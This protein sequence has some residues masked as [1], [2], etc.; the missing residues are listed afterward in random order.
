MPKNHRGGAAPPYELPSV[1]IRHPHVSR[2]DL[3]HFA[4]RLR[5]IAPEGSEK[6]RENAD[7]LAFRWLIGSIPEVLEPGID[8]GHDLRDHS[9]REEE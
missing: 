8:K 7:G 4:A 5:R 3:P 9:R 1:R 6:L 2:S